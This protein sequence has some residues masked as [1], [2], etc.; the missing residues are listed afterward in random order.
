MLLGRS[1]ALSRAL[2]SALS[3]QS[4]LPQHCLGPYYGFFQTLDP[5]KP[6]SLG[7]R[8]GFCVLFS[9][10]DMGEVHKQPYQIFF[11]HHQ[12][13]SIFPLGKKKNFKN[14]HFSELC[15]PIVFWRTGCY[16]SESSERFWVHMRILFPSKFSGEL[17]GRSDI[18]SVECFYFALFYN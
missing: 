5:W 1:I 7:L 11:Q 13:V 12:I 2:V 10:K 3:L 9:V 4:R 8:P 18:W 16:G 15:F 14:T 6:L 17:I